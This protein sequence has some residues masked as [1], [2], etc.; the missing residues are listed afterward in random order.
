MIKEEQFEVITK[1]SEVKWS[2]KAKELYNNCKLIQIAKE[3]IDTKDKVCAPPT[4]KQ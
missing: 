2:E 3:G 1:H 4:I